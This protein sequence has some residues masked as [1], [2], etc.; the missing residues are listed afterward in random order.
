MGVVGE[1]NAHLRPS[2]SVHSGIATCAD[3]HPSSGIGRGLAA[4]HVQ[5]LV[6]ARSTVV[7]SITPQPAESGAGAADEYA[8]IFHSAD[9]CGAS[10][11][12]MERELSRSES[13]FTK[14]VAV[15]VL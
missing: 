15:R 10:G 14:P 7:P 4:R 8:A 1:R 9:E 6:D 12:S 3:G 11:S 5:P 13:M 2:E